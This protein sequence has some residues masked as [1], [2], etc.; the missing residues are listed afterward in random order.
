MAAVLGSASLGPS[1]FFSIFTV[2]NFL[3]RGPFTTKFCTWQHE[4]MLQIWLLCFFY[5][6]VC[7]YIVAEPYVTDLT[8]GI[9]WIRHMNKMNQREW[10][11]ASL[12]QYSKES[13]R[14]YNQLQ[15]NS[16]TAEPLYRQLR[17]WNSISDQVK[18]KHSG[19]DI[20]DVS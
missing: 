17:N 2:F 9:L 7:A 19:P 12:Q 10:I 5:F 16:I 20:H 8:C 14:T 3:K 6:L 13:D 11:K 15:Y 18:H 1:V 4:Q